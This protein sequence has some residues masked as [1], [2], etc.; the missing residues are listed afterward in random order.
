MAS[1]CVA[2]IRAV[3]PEG[4]YSLGGYCVAGSVAYEIA[5]QLVKAGES[6]AMLT[7]ID[8]ARPTA[9]RARLLDLWYELQLEYAV[10]R[11]KHIATVIRDIVLAKGIERKRLI[12]EVWRRKFGSTDE[13]PETPPRYQVSNTILKH[14]RMM[15]AYRPK[16]YPGCITLIVCEK[17]YRFDKYPSWAGLAQGGIHCHQLPGDHMA[18]L[19]VHS[20]DVARFLFESTAR[21]SRPSVLHQRSLFASPDNRSVE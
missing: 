14:W 5:Q 9:V 17:W 16:P 8:A 1:E 18:L 20:P 2:E 6:V 7:L 15:L 4:P 19:T 21:N 13:Q 12:A 3:Q 11:V 10:P